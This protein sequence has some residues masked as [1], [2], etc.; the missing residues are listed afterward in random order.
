MSYSQEIRAHED[1]DLSHVFARAA[2]PVEFL[3]T[4]KRENALYGF[5]RPLDHAEDLPAIECLAA[6]IRYGR[7]DVVV[8]GTGGSSLGAHALVALKENRFSH[9]NQYPRIHFPDNL[10]PYTMDAL[11]SE[12]DLA[13]THFLIISK[14]GGTAETLAQMMACLSAVKVMLERVKNGRQLSDY[15]TVI[16]EPGDNILRRFANRWRLPIFDHAQDIGGRYSAL[17]VV[18]L[19]PSAIAGL[20][21]RETRRGAREVLMNC[22]ETDE[23]ENIPAAVGAATIYGCAEEG[24]NIN[25][26]MPYECRL[27]T[28]AKWH[29]Q[30]WAE[31]VGKAGKGTTPVRALGPVDQHSQLQLYLDGPNDKFFTFITTEMNGKGPVIDDKLASDPELGYM[32]GRTVGDLVAAE[33]RATMEALSRHDKPVRQLKLEKLNEY[34]MGGLIMHFMLET[35]IGAHLFDVNPFD[36]PAVEE[37]KQLTRQYMEWGRRMH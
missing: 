4:Q 26:L 37:G 7:N 3:K 33:A 19:L 12:L 18:G 31:S 22:L 10:G 2:E 9:N 32:S 17:S 8:L 36:Q 35:I 24:I 13:S 29:Q 25:V 21:I 6:T 11:L 34:S 28:F 23:V 1:R 14:S 20:D 30:L 15:F 5:L 27:D 16:V